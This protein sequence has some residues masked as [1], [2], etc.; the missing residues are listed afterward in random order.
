MK[1]NMK[2]KPKIL[3]IKMKGF[4]SAVQKS[5]ILFKKNIGYFPAKFFWWFKFD[6]AKKL[7]LISYNVISICLLT[8]RIEFFVFISVPQVC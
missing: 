7:N 6:D 1:A 4:D 2:N 3:A 8:F 5:N